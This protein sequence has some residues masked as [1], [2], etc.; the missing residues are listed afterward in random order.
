MT[1]RRCGERF[2]STEALAAHLSRYKQKTDQLLKRIVDLNL[3]SRGADSHGLNLGCD[4]CGRDIFG[5]QPFPRA[6]D[7]FELATVHSAQCRA[8]VEN[9]LAKLNVICT[10]PISQA[11]AK[12]GPSCS[13][14]NRTFRLNIELSRH[15]K[16][17]HAAS[18]VDRPV[19]EVPGAR[20][21]E[22]SG[23]ISVEEPSLLQLISQ[24]GGNRYDSDN[25]EKPCLSGER[26]ECC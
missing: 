13:L 11:L 9:E 19:D 15:M 25:G 4:S 26:T 1:F 12:D 16:K 24:Q 22:A 2:L 14:C 7:L 18:K 17:H 23:T 10:K 5:G 6:A 21:V 8:E 20:L 3:C